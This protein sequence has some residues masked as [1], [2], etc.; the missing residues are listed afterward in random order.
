MWVGVVV[1]LL[2]AWQCELDPSLPEN[3]TEHAASQPLC[4]G[5]LNASAPPY[6]AVGDGVVDDTAALQS[7]LDDAYSNRLAVLLPASKVFL[8]THQLKAI[9]NGDPPAKRAY[10]YQL[11]GAT[12]GDAPRAVIRV[13]DNVDLEGFPP[14]FNATVD[15]GWYDARPVLRYALLRN[16]VEQ[17]PSHYGA[18]LR[19]VDFDMGVN[20]RLSAVSMDG[21]QLCSI[22]DVRIRGESFTAGVVAL[23]G[24][25]GY[26]A[27]LEVTNGSFAIWQNSHRPNPSV[28]GLT[29]LNQIVAAV[30]LQNSRG[31]LVISGFVIRMSRLATQAILTRFVCCAHGDGSLAL[32]DG[33]IEFPDDAGENTTAISNSDAR[34]VSLKSVWIQ[35][36][37]A[38][39]AGSLRVSADPTRFREI[40]R[41]SFS[42]GAIAWSKGGNVSMAAGVTG[43]PA[44]KGKDLPVSSPPPDRTL[45][46]IHS[47]SV[48]QAQEIAW[49]TGMTDAWRDCGAT[50]SWVN[51]TD[52]D[53]AALAKCL[54]RSGTVFLPRGEYHVSSPLMLRGNNKLVGAGKHC[55]SLFMRGA[56]L[57]VVGGASGVLSDLTLV[58]SHRSVL[59]GVNG[60]GTLL[61]DVRTV[62]CSTKPNP[63]QPVCET[64]AAVGS[65]LPVAGIQFTGPASGRFFGLSLDHFST[66]LT[67]TGDALLAVN[68]SHGSGLHLYQLSAEHLPSDYQVQVWRSSNVHLHAFKFES[69]GFV[70]HPS[71]GPFGGGLLACHS[72]PNTSIFGGSGNYGIM[73][74]TIAPNIVFAWGCPDLRLDGMVRK[75]QDEEAPPSV[76]NW[77]HATA[78]SGADPIVI[79]DGVED[80]LTFSQG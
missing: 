22:E 52:D 33:L 41:W 39:T 50:P 6:N 73:N 64:A 16:G 59:L 20:H 44:I 9:Q 19:N 42:H 79:P 51:A 67:Q 49:S 11:I 55:A 48:G 37:V 25:G 23:P 26:S 31:P 32:E 30:L 69:S 61:R 7:A 34:D 72:S 3:L 10:G 12:A 53:G 1:A 35:A 21:A 75:K 76:A 28:S 2:G 77:V 18:L 56:S 24:S 27:N 70:A 62:P 4:A 40:T 29:A 8:V 38:V 46:T 36:G 71:W 66:F 47:W 43:V 5:F 14:L 57:V 58:Q 15:G 68:D 60:T 63:N 65:A 54:K 80:L 78:V 74:A 17:P 13:K 45:G